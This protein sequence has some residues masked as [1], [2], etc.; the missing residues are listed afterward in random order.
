MN[1]ENIMVSNT[2]VALT[3]REN[4]EALVRMIRRL[5]EEHGAPALIVV[6][7]LARNCVK[8]KVWEHQ[9]SN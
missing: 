7:T 5:T 4:V 3:E 1:L 8:A 9:S 6:D 2:A